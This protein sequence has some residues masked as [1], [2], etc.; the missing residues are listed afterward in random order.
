MENKISKYVGYEPYEHD[1]IFKMPGIS[2]VNHEIELN[3]EFKNSDIY[4]IKN[5]KRIKIIENGEVIYPKA[6]FFIV[7][8]ICPPCVSRRKLHFYLR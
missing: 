7:Y 1:G 6:L 2:K 8:G 3:K 5:G 4:V